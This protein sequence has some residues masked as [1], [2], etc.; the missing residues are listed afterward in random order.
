ME[1]D[2]LAAME[3]RFQ[4]FRPVIQTWILPPPFS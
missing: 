3:D 1:Q 2:A 4:A